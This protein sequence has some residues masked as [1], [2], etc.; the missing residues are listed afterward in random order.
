MLVG[1]SGHLMWFT[2]T[3][4]AIYYIWN[5]Q[6]SERELEEH[7]ENWAFKMST[8]AMKNPAREGQHT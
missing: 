1:S 5:Q 7:A 4:K 3:V 8:T 2:K 6:L